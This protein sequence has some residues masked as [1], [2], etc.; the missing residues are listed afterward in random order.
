[1]YV[2]AS[3][4]NYPHKIF[5]LESAGL[6]CSSFLVNLTFWYHMWSEQSG[7]TGDATLRVDTM[8]ESGTWS[9]VPSPKSQL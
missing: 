5:S 6:P 7:Y 3:Q 1:M 9:E 8:T 4:P 2:E